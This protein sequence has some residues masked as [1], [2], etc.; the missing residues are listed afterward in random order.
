MELYQTI[1]VTD[2]SF[3]LLLDPYRSQSSG[4][5]WYIQAIE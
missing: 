4:T 2:L 5:P 3:L 1:I